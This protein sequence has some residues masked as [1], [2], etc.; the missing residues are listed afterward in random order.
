MPVNGV[1]SIKKLEGTIMK[2]LKFFLILS[3][4]I[5]VGSGFSHQVTRIVRPYILLD[6][7]KTSNVKIGDQLFLYRMGDDGQAG[8]IGKVQVVRIQGTDCGA[9]ILFEDEENPIQLGDRLMTIGETAVKQSATPST[10]RAQ[11]P[12]GRVFQPRNNQWISFAAVGAG[13][14]AA[15]LGYHY[16][17][18]A[19]QLSKISPVKHQ[20]QAELQNTV[21]QYDNRSNFSTYL[22][23]GLI[24]FGVVHYFITRNRPVAQRQAINIQ[25]IQKKDYLGVGVQ[26]A[27]KKP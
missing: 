3:C 9:R 15:G 1:Y 4:L 6:I 25:T 16:Y 21:R 10:T 14:V 17:W 11:T 23:G 27:L 24:V 7:E 19:E 18:E 13:L 26:L 22:G 5:W 8:V 20:H 2:A 12:S